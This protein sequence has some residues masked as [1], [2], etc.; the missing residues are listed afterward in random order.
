[1]NFKLI[2]TCSEISILARLTSRRVSGTTVMNRRRG[3]TG[4]V[5]G[6][7][8]GH[9]ET[10]VD[11]TGIGTALEPSNRGRT[12]LTTTATLRLRTRMWRKTRTTEKAWRIS[13]LQSRTARK[14]D[15]GSLKP[16]PSSNR[17]PWGRGAQ[18]SFYPHQLWRP[19]LLT[20][21]GAPSVELSPRRLTGA[22]VT[23]RIILLKFHHN[24]HIPFVTPGTARRR[25][26]S[27]SGR[28]CPT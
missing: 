24:L 12:S 11:N 13:M 7:R 2:I 8:L 21:K 16:P 10:V 28:Q 18:A 1:L 17:G 25:Q 6:I 20:T 4:P 27:S 5:R 23:A 9:A 19:M 14:T 3:M 22:G 26:K 15:G